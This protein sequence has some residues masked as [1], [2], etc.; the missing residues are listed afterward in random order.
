MLQNPIALP[1][2]ATAHDDRLLHGGATLSGC[3][4]RSLA[5]YFSRLGDQS[6][7]DLYDLVVS[8][9]E[10]PLLD[11]VL[12]E[13]QGNVSRAATILGINRGT[14]RKKLK[15]YGIKAMR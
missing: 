5:E 4:R 2:P 14:L 9:I 1:S 3:V 8:E 10:K 6:P 11:V 15:R 12:T 7:A 13:T